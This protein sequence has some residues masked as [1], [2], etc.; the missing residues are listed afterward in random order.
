MKLL[1][2]YELQK[3]VMEAINIKGTSDFPTI[4]LNY[5]RGWIY[6]RGSSLPENVLD[7]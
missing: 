6:L 4:I 3:S 5:E 1:T 2:W 7:I